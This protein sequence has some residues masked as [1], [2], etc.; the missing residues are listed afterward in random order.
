MIAEIV[1]ETQLPSLMIAEKIPDFSESSIEKKSCNGKFSDLVP[2]FSIEQITT[3]NENLEGKE[4]PIT[5]VPFKR[6]EVEN[7]FG[8]IVDGVFPE[9]EAIFEA[10]LPSDLQQ[11]TDNVQFKE[12]NR[13]LS[14]RLAKYPDEANNIFDA[15][16]LDDIAN[17]R[18]PE[19]YTW[20]H[21]ED[22]GK[23]QLVDTEDHARTAHTGGK[24]LWGG[25][26][27][28]R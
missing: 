2:D 16:Q 5:G 10:Q 26:N 13:Q 19:G 4:H 3:R 21:S 11:S 8:K 7:S 1:K 22:M 24:V 25:G 15:D 28:N 18:T 14:E 27:E 9:F 23:M 20:H 12:S 6:K 17:G